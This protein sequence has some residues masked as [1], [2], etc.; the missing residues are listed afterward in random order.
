MGGFMSKPVYYLITVIFLVTA[1]AVGQN[2]LSQPE[3]VAFDTLNNR[4]LVSNVGDA[5]IIQIETDFVTQSY[6]K[7]ALGRYCLGN[8]IVND[9]FFVTVYPSYIKGYDLSTDELVADL[10]IP[11]AINLDGMAA[12]TSGNLYVVDTQN[13]RI[14]KILLSDYSYSTFVQGLSISPQ[15]IAFDP[16]E[17]RLLVCYYSAGAT[18]DEISLPTGTRTVAVT[19][20]MGSFDGITNDGQGNTFV[21]THNQGGRVYMFNSD[22]TNPPT[23]ITT[24]PTEP[25]GLDYNK[26]DKILAIP[27]FYDNRIDFLSF[28]DVD[29]DGYL[30]YRDN[31]PNISNPNQED[32][33]GDGNGDL[34]DLCPGYND[35][36]DDD[37]DS[38]PNDCDNCPGYDDNADADNDGL[39]DDCD[40]CPNGSNPGQEDGDAD[41]I[42]DVCDNCPEHYN[43]GQ[44]DGN[45][46]NVGDVCDY[47]CGDTNN[48][49]IVNILDIV[50]LINNIYKAGTNPVYPASA[51]VNSD[52]F[53]NILDIVYLINNI[54]KAGPVPYCG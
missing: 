10:V 32:S 22:F 30:D 8:Q 18:I 40:N 14:Y 11:T 6:Y 2:L 35:N 50:F 46:N 21:A 37:G 15:D 24:L 43:P 48:D 39:A 13:R 23:L 51:D 41:G 5:A 31:C 27:S 53:K 4:Y 7:T 25:S 29:E 20:T 1:T 42:G 19:T 49:R 45:E 17:N 47:I 54:Y 44:E 28:K 9:I 38:A 36:L 26:R 12:D 16:I 52:G 34:C 33:D 3:S